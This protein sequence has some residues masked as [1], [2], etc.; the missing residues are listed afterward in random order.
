[1]LRLDFQFDSINTLQLSQTT[2]QL[3]LSA[4]SLILTLTYWE[5]PYT[6]GQSV[7]ICVA[8]FSQAWQQHMQTDNTTVLSDI[9]FILCAERL[10]LLPENCDISAVSIY[11]RMSI[12]H[13]SPLHPRSPKRPRCVHQNEQHNLLQSDIFLIKKHTH[14]T[15]ILS[16]GAF[17]F[18]LMGRDVLVSH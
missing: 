9:F 12:L 5:M 15:H 1:M 4:T 13:C 17:A 18:I 16:L 3:S 2:S 10:I 7:S 11:A 8:V 6:Y 14:M